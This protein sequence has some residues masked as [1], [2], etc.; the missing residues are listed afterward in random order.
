MFYRERHLWFTP[1][2]ALTCASEASHTVVS[3][4]FLFLLLPAAEEEPR[5]L[6]E[7]I[8]QYFQGNRWISEL[9][10]GQYQG[11]SSQCYESILYSSRIECASMC[12]CQKSYLPINTR[13]LSIHTTHE[14]PRYACCDFVK[15]GRVSCSNKPTENRH[16]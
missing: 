11:R 9:L 12:R 13:L 7:S 16:V 15:C 8:Q 2:A 10:K 1:Q 5:A 4:G 6:R 3:H 14:T